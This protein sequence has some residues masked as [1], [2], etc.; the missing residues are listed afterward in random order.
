MEQLRQKIDQAD[1]KLLASF[2]ERMAVVAEIAA[3]KVAH[4][5]PVTDQHREKRIIAA[6]QE[7]AG[8]ALA[9][10]VAR[11]WQ[12]LFEISCDYQQKL[13]QGEPSASDGAE[14]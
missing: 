14:R 5:L 9:E 10:D 3:Y 2:V 1:Q 7:Q 4:H 6:L 12:L 8:A 11:L 13:M